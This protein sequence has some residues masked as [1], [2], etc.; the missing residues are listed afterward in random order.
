MQNLTTS[1]VVIL[2]VGVWAGSGQRLVEPEEM[3]EEGEGLEEP[4]EESGDQSLLLAGPGEDL[5][6]V[7]DGLGERVRVA[8]LH[9]AVGRGALE[10]PASA[11]GGV[12]VH[13]EVPEVLR[14]QE[15]HQVGVELVVEAVHG[16]GRAGT[17]LQAGAVEQTEATGGGLV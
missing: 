7:P 12:E 6:A 2:R 8:G 13:L 1:Y 16:V 4:V 15:P 17:V 5:L 3:L 14:L 11:A 9:A 10:V